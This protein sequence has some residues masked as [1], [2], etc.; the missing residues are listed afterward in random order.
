MKHFIILL[1][2]LLGHFPT[3]T[4]QNQDLPFVPPI[5]NYSQTQYKAGLQN[6]QISQCKTGV[7]YVANN[8]GLLTFDGQVW[9]LHYLP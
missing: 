5:Y 9:Q 8:Q 7:L 3:T 6:W 4:A 1:I 2:I